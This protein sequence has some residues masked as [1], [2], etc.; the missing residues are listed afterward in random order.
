MDKIVARRLKKIFKEQ[1]VHQ[2]Q[3]LRKY[4]N[5][6]Q[7]M[8]K[9]IVNLLEGTFDKDAQHIVL[10]TGYVTYQM[11]KNQPKYSEEMKI[12]EQDMLN[13]CACHGIVCILDLVKKITA[14][15]T[16]EK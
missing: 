14:D 3:F 1:M 4:K 15:W 12:W 5:C 9:T 16:K 10:H 7:F 11:L 8:I 13:Q 2:A 6:D